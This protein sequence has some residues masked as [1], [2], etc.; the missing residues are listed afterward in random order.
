MGFLR[1]RTMSQIKHGEHVQLRIEFN[2]CLI[3]CDANEM[4]L[5]AIKF[6]K[7][8]YLCTFMVLIE[9]L[10][11]LVFSLYERYFNGWH[12]WFYAFF[13][14]G[15]CEIHLRRTSNSSWYILTQLFKLILT[16]RKGPCAA[17]TIKGRLRDPKWDHHIF[18]SYR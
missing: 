14:L 17:S 16:K 11:I 12:S 5:W 15:P 13:S 10:D 1:L 9:P 4:N 3:S 7:L 8:E 6:L 2:L 18:I